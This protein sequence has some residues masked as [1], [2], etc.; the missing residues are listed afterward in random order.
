MSMTV[1]TVPLA[2]VVL[3]P[4][5]VHKHSTKNVE[6]ITGSLARFGQ[7]TPIVIDAGGV[8]YKGNGT[9]LA[10]RALGWTE[11]KVVRYL[12]AYAIADNVTQS[13]DYDD[14][15]L[16][17]TLDSI[18]REDEKLFAA[19][20]FDDTGYDALIKS[21]GDT[22]L[23]EASI[24]DVTASDGR[25][26]MQSGKTVRVVVLVADLAFI[27]RVLASTGEHIKGRALAIVCKAYE[28]SHPV[29]KA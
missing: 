7:R 21:I 28:E 12:T 11:I 4:A 24:S 16:A 27:E 26:D 18:K 10:A 2:S 9:V 8:V 19:T 13:P 29:S 20:G 5:N 6:A 15:A 22:K 17:K 25:E 23:A 14:L 1:E 3:D